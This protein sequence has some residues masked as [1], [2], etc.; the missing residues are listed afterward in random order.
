MDNRIAAL[1]DFLN[2]SHSVFHAIHGIEKE[3]K[4]Q[5]Y[6]R[7]PENREWE[8]APG[9]KYYVIRGGTAVISFRIPEGTP[10]GF[11]MSASH[12]DRP[13][14][15]VK[16]NFEIS[17]IYTKMAVERY[18]G[19]IWTGLCLWQAVWWWSRKTVWNAS[20]WTLTGICC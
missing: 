2:A 9:G 10:K 16:E 19:M 4:D 13:G 3:L 17:G 14:F 11:M 8:L 5:G 1:C 7:L 20:W 15:R 12:S 6:V 18:G